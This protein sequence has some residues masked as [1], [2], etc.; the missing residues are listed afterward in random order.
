M[1]EAKRILYI[2]LLPLVII[3]SSE[4]VADEAGN[5][6]GITNSHNELRAALNVRGLT[7][8]DELA[9]V[10][11]EWA[12]H[13][14]KNNQCKMKHRP[15]HG[16]YSRHYGENIFWASALRWSD[17][18]R[19]VQKISPDIVVKSWASEAKNYSYNNNT[20]R[21]GKICGHY[22]QVVWESSTRLGCGMAVCPDNG[23]I[24]VCSYDP[25]GNYI[26]R[27]PY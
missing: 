10:A 8:S 2:L 15:K 9:G 22:T 5:M 13:L 17:G 23:Q 20:C 7:W 25:P 4:T 12:T 11:Q 18:K 1:S 19:E 21:K 24:W 3:I 26:G 27:K 6:I 16:N 14:A